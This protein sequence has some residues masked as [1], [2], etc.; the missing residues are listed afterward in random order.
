MYYPKLSFEDSQTLNNSIWGRTQRLGDVV[1]G[2]D[3]KTRAVNALVLWFIVIQDSVAGT[4]FER[5]YTTA[6]QLRWVDQLC[7]DLLSLLQQSK[8][9]LAVIR[10]YDPVMGLKSFRSYKEWLNQALCGDLFEFLRPLLYDLYGGDNGSYLR[11]NTIL[12]FL[13]RLTLHDV[14]GLEDEAISSYYDQEV[15]MRSWVY[16][17]TLLDCLRYIVTEWFKGMSVDDMHPD[18]SNGATAEV[19]R[20]AGVAQKVRKGRKTIDLLCAEAESSFSSPY[21]GSV[22]VGYIPIAEYQTVP[23]GLDRRRGISKEPTANQYFQYALFKRFD[24]W[25]SLHPEIRVDLHDQTKSQRLALKGS[26]YYNYATA[27]LSNASDNVTWELVQQLFRDL[28]NILRYLRLVRTQRVRIPLTKTYA[29]S[30]GIPWR[31]RGTKGKPALVITQLAKYAPMGSS[32]CFPMECI[33]FAACASYACLLAGIPQNFRVY[34]DDIVI[35]C[36]AYAYLCEI[37]S[38]LHFTVN[39]EKSYSY[40]CFT[41]ACGIECYRGSDVTPLRLSRKYDMCAAFAMSPQQLNSLI[42]LANNLY[43][44]GLFKARRYVIQQILA[45][46]SLVPFSVNPETGIYHPTPTNTHLTSRKMASRKLEYDYQTFCIEVYRSHSIV[47]RGDQDIRY[48]RH[49][50]ATENRL[51]LIDPIDRVE[52]RCGRTRTSLRKEWLPFATWQSC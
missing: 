16:P 1:L 12:Q 11:L 26:K 25:F 45:I 7:V 29:K 43:E 37:L 34:G 52:M 17:D 46:Y 10:A 33:V 49:L 47:E 42:D 2:Q 5:A 36:R 38:R 6:N 44:Y 40:S 48:L 21:F 4:R 32:L 30:H 13:S 15:E 20:G 51:K 28:P 31:K 27:D 23:K 18:F 3:D 35:D 9:I 39:V 22:D 41:E 8:E 19:R 14:E 24:D 50:E